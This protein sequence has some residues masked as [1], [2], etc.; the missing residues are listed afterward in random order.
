MDLRVEELHQ[1]LAV[2]RIEGNGLDELRDQLRERVRR[3]PPVLLIRA[4]GEEEAGVEPSRD[5][6]AHA[7]TEPTAAQRARD[8]LAARRAA[9][10]G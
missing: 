8:E 10:A 9:H 1:R 6:G 4:E 3:P 2:E 7:A 5:P